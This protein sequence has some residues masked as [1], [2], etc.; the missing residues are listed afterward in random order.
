MYHALGLT[1]YCG[2][3]WVCGVCGQVYSR[4]FGGK[5]VVKRLMSRGLVV[6]INSDDPAYFGGYIGDNFV[7]CVEELGL[8]RDALVELATNS[9]TSTFLSEEEKAALVAEVRAFAASN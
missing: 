7:A 6:T 4:Y 1:M 3:C 5:N 8:G 9:F 2:V